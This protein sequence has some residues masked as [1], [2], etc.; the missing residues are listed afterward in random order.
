MSLDSIR[1]RQEIQ[2]DRKIKN[3]ARTYSALVLTLLMIA[4]L[5]PFCSEIKEKDELFEKAILVQFDEED[6]M[7]MASAEKS[8]SKAAANA[9]AAA[10][11]ESQTTEETATTPEPTPV[12]TP[13]ENPQPEKPTPTKIDPVPIKPSTQRPVLTSPEPAEINYE[14]M[15]QELPETAQVEE[16]SEE[17][18]EV[19][20]EV[21]ADFMAEL[22]DFFKNSSSDKP[23]SS[24]SSSS[25]GSSTGGSGTAN[26]DKPDNG[27]SSTSGEGNSGTSSTGDSDTDGVGNSGTSGNDFEGDGLLTRKV[28]KRANLD[29]I[30]KKNGKIV[31]NLCVDQNGAVIF[32]KADKRS[33]SIKDPLLLKKAERAAG[34]YRYEKDYTAAKRQCGKLTVI[35]KGIE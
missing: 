5:A 28:I 21:S 27:T 18:T 22:A 12:E 34:R 33:S 1:I 16:V 15:I 11:E 6:F 19:T 20:E 26:N 2:T 14:D 3:K 10:E 35:I 9:P 13:P 4:L 30:I 8:S 25:S 31:I 32:T 7:D 17:V 23:S 24:E 29:K